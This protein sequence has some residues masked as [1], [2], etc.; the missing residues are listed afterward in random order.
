MKLTKLEYLR[1][2]TAEERIA[3]RTV[4]KSNPVLEDYLSMLELADEIDIAD[5]DTVAAVMMLEQGGLLAQGRAAEILADATAVT[6][7]PEPELPTGFAMVYR[8]GDNFVTCLASD[9]PPESFD[10]S[11]QVPALYYAMIAEGASLRAE[12]GKLAIAKQVG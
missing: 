11:W 4:A 9:V 3:I 5:T 6:V 1:K 10:E 8:I 12:E 7:A 2:F